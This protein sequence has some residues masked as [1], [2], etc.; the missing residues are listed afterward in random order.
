MPCLKHQKVDDGCVECFAA[1]ILAFNL[2]NDIVGM[3]ENLLDQGLRRLVK[4][5]GQLK[6]SLSKDDAEYC[7]T[8]IFGLNTKLAARKHALFGMEMAVFLDPNTIQFAHR[9]LYRARL[10]KMGTWIGYS[11]FVTLADTYRIRFEC[12]PVLERFVNGWNARGVKVGSE[13]LSNTLYDDE[14]FEKNLRVA[15]KPFKALI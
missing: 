1:D 3:K 8:L 5:Y 14:Y 7:N 9:Q 15:L 12:V 6:E 4:R 11:E 10:R 13:I 2:G